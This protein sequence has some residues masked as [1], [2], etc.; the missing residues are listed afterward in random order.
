MTFQ[1]EYDEDT[2]R[3]MDELN[4]LFSDYSEQLMKAIE[5]SSLTTHQKNSA[6]FN[7]IGRNK[8]SDEIV[9]VHSIAM[10]VKYIIDKKDWDNFNV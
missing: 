8:I 2:Q 6:F 1:V 3:V 4:K 5:K 9:R 7:D 10:P